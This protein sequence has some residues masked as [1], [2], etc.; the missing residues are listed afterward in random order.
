MPV[1]I[2]GLEPPESI[3]NPKLLSFLENLFRTDQNDPNH[4]LLKNIQRGTSFCI[5]ADIYVNG[6]DLGDFLVE[7]GFVKRIL[8]VP[9]RQQESNAVSLVISPSPVP[10]SGIMQPVAQPNQQKS[11]QEQ[12]FVASKSSKIFHSADCPH[13]KRISEE[14]TVYFRT[15]EQAINSGRR[16]CK[17]CRP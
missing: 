1:R 10:A 16:P 14:R 15:R 4:I 6:K 5:H 12:R 9:S 7:K 11:T 8:K 3:P 2:R 13:T 17:T